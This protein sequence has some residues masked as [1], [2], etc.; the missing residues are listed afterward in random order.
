MSNAVRCKK[1]GADFTT[2]NND[3]FLSDPASTIPECLFGFPNTVLDDG[4]AH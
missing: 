4:N 2:I 1:G 3:A